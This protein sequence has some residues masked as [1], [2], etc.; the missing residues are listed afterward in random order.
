MAIF[1]FK[2]QKYKEA[3]DL[4]TEGLN[5][6]PGDYGLYTNRGDCFKAMNLFVKALEDYL[7]AFEIEKKSQELNFRISTIYSIRGV[8]LFNSKNYELALREFE[9]SLRFTPKNEKFVASRAKCLIQLNRKEE[10]L[11]V[12]SECVKLNPTFNEIK[13]LLAQVKEP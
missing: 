5:F 1:L 13:A 12:L 11:E 2:Q 8:S 3:I 10:A 9:E 4:F 7:L 6:N